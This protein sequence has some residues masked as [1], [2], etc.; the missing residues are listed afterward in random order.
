MATILWARNFDLAKRSARAS[1]KLILVDFYTDWCTYCKKLDR[2]IFPDNRV[3]QALSAVVPVRLN[4][5]RE[6]AGL[7]RQ[8]GVTSYPT[9]LFLDES[10]NE[11][12]R[13]SGFLP[14][15]PFVSEVESAVKTHRELPQRI[16]KVKATPN[17]T[18]AALELLKTY[19]M[20]RR[21]QPSE[22][23]AA[24]IQRIDPTNSR[25]QLAEAL[26]LVGEL[27]LQTA[28][29]DKARRR[30][31]MAEKVSKRPLDRG[32]ALLNLGVC[33]AQDRNLPRAIG[34]WKRAK[35]LPGAPA[36]ITKFADSLLQRA[37]QLKSGGG[38]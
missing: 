11:S 13:I 14:V 5:E 6:G 2:D 1:K 16:A 9:L 21:T 32:I 17:D 37:A 10:G 33:D 27:N 20:M 4:A 31:T 15:G 28:F 22:A 25:G 12:G 26:N 38:R 30:F 8:F 23:L 34:Y 18:K 36:N 7:A 35:S 29:V 3:V 19:A 24:Q